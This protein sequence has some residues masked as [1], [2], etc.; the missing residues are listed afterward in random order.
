MGDLRSC[1][2]GRPIWYSISI[3][4][5]GVSLGDSKVKVL[6]TRPAFTSQC[7]SVCGHTTSKNRESQAAFACRACG[8][9]NNADVNAAINILNRGL[10]DFAAGL[11]VTGRGAERQ[12]S[13]PT[14]DEAVGDET[15]TLS[16]HRPLVAV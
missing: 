4:H 11:A 15:S 6:D 10:Q 7:C 1:R 9:T 16:V 12:P 13:P 3:M 2:R 8:Y 14:C 5:L